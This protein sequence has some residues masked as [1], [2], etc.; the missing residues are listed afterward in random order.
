MSLLPGTRDRAG[1]AV[2]LVRGQDTFAAGRVKGKV[3]GREKSRTKPGTPGETL[4]RGISRMGPMGRMGLLTGNAH[5]PAGGRLYICLTRVTAAARG[6]S[7][8]CAASVGSVDPAGVKGCVGA[9]LRGC[10]IRGDPRLLTVEAS[11]LKGAGMHEGVVESVVAGWLF[12]D[13]LSGDRV[14]GGVAS[15]AGCETV[16]GSNANEKSNGMAAVVSVDPA[17]VRGFGAA[18]RGCRVRGDRP[19][20]HCRGLRPERQDTARRAVL[21]N[22]GGLSTPPRG[23]RSVARSQE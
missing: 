16:V 4:G 13:S 23:S 7:M 17:G 2:R 9:M 1:D 6:G 20:T 5:T 19:A 10:R 3:R 15:R 18:L 12:R 11:G 22:Q 21:R 14:L 8:R